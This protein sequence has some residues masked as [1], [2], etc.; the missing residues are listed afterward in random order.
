[1]VRCKYSEDPTDFLAQNLVKWAAFCEDYGPASIFSIPVLYINS[2]AK[3][4]QYHHF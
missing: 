1:M 3:M 2:W 4:A